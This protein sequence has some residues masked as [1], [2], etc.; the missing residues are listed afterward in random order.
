[1]S[2]KVSEHLPFGVRGA[3]STRCLSIST[4]IEE[5][6]VKTLLRVRCGGYDKT[7]VSTF[8]ENKVGRFRQ[9]AMNKQEIQ[10]LQTRISGKHLPFLVNV[11]P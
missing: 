2:F 9:S 7:R 8:S 10:N 3:T 1:M 5:S 6:C 4:M 11:Q